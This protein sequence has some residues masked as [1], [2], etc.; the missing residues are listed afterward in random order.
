MEKADTLQGKLMSLQGQ[1]T[2]ADAVLDPK[3]DQI[4]E[5]KTQNEV[6]QE[7]PDD[8]RKKLMN[9]LTPRGG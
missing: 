3:E 5:F 8:A 7:I 1:F 6:Q 9:S 2:E 4:E